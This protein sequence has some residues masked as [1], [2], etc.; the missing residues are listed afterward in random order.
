MTPATTPSPT[1]PRE[2]QAEQRR[3]RQQADALLDTAT[4]RRLR[5]QAGYSTRRFARALGVSAS[6]VRSLEEGSNHDQLPLTLLAC[7]AEL[8]GVTPQELFAGLRPSMW[9]VGTLV[10]GL[11]GGFAR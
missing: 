5:L 3:L 11:S 6:T 7:L 8:L 9:V 4:L 2:V 10:L 1:P